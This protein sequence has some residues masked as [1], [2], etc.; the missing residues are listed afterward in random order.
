MENRKQPPDFHLPFC[1]LLC[2][3][4]SRNLLSQYWRQIGYKKPLSVWSSTATLQIGLWILA[5]LYYSQNITLQPVCFEFYKIHFRFHFSGV[6]DLE[7][8]FVMF[9]ICLGR[10]LEWPLSPL[11]FMDVAS[12]RLEGWKL[13]IWESRSAWCC[14]YLISLLQRVQAPIEGQ[15]STGGH[16]RKLK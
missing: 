10:K 9:S 14:D 11:T 13:E 1:W 6:C 2:K 5:K 3:T 16:I 7:Y 8:Y 4:W 15:F 12:K